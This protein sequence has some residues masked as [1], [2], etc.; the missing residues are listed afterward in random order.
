MRDLLRRGLAIAIGALA[1]G[2]AALGASTARS[3]EA[4]IAVASNFAP[5]AE[6]F[7]RALEAETPHRIH[8]VR[9]STGKLFAQIVHGAP[10]DVFLA[11]DAARPERLVA[12][13]RAVAESRRAYAFGRLV[14]L[15]SAPP[16]GRGGVE[17]RLRAGDF[18]RLAIAR[19]ELAPYGAAAQATIARLGRSEALASKLVYGENIGQTFALVASRAADL[20]FVAAAQLVGRDVEAGRLWRVPADHHPPIRQELVLLPRAAQ[21][22]AARA[23]LEALGS[24]A[25]RARIRAAGYEVE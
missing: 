10:F 20:G 22:P 1:I 9:G 5:V 18:D 11:A 23:F 8:L 3:A 24:E 12:E 21:N 6:A 15:S 4:V 7:A 14:L 2:G 19:P 17:S 13:G 16:E 25:G